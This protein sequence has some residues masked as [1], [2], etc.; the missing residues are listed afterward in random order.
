MKFYMEWLEG[1]TMDDDACVNCGEPGLRL[2]CDGWCEPC[3]NEIRL[4]E[5]RT[6]QQDYSDR[7]AAEKMREGTYERP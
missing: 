6:E 7:L 2:D 1:N 4:E 5:L 3:Y